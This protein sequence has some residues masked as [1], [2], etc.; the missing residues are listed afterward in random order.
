MHHRFFP[1]PPSRSPSPLPSSFRLQS[2]L[3][4]SV[5]HPATGSGRS[6]YSMW[7]ELI[8]GFLILAWQLRAQHDNAV[9]ANAE[10]DR[11]ALHLEI[12]KDTAAQVS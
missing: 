1:L 11:N 9:R 6:Q 4:C 2:M 8:S 7:W 3:S 5:A 10:R 12:Y